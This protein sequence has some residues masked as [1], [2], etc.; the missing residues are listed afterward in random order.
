[1][2]ALTLVLIAAFLGVGLIVT[3]ISM[4]LGIAWGMIAAGVGFCAAAFI[5]RRG[6]TPDGG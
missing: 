6:L 3:G 5:L 2:S 4:L 1:V